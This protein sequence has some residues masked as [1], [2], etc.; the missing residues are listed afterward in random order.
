[1]YEMLWENETSAASTS[2]Y[3]SLRSVTTDN[4]KRDSL[5]FDI[6]FFLHE[7]TVA[8]NKRFVYPQKMQQVYT[9]VIILPISGNDV[10]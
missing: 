3:Q 7:Y 5:Q 1:M 10:L 8:G 4:I 6:S 9:C 2:L